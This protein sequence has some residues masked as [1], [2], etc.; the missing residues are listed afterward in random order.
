MLSRVV[1]SS[2]SG[3]HGQPTP[4][5]REDAAADRRSSPS[6][7]LQLHRPSHVDLALLALRSFVLRCSSILVTG[8]IPAREAPTMLPRGLRVLWPQRPASQTLR[9]PPT[10]YGAHKHRRAA[11][12]TEGRVFPAAGR[13]GDRGG[14]AW[15]VPRSPI[16]SVK[17]PTRDTI[18]HPRSRPVHPPNE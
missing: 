15:W 10:G 2:R 4:S 1:P 14:S 13:L 5:D 12:V 7:A 17:Q 18:L 6:T 8:T 16:R 11:V 3:L 9:Q